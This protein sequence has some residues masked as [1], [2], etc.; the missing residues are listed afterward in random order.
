MNRTVPFSDLFVFGVLALV[1]VAEP[2]SSASITVE[3]CTFAVDAPIAELLLPPAVGM[4]LIF[5][6]AVQAAAFG[7]FALS[8]VSIVVADTAVTVDMLE[9]TTIS[10]SGVGLAGVDPGR[11]I[12]VALRD[13]SFA[14]SFGG[15]LVAVVEVRLSPFLPA[16]PSRIA[17]LRVS[18]SRCTVSARQLLSLSGSTVAGAAFAVA[19]SWAATADLPPVYAAL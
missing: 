17:S 19:D 3:N 18:A 15:S 11:D 10:V 2:L 7:S 5:A 8:N 1:F 4:T 16:L 12:S 9:T 14:A 13:V 6:G